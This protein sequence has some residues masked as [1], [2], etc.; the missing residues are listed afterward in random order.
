M[1]LGALCAHSYPEHQPKEKT[2][3]RFINLEPQLNDKSSVIFINLE[4]QQ[5]E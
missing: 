3:E 4:S 2:Y 5:K 1:G